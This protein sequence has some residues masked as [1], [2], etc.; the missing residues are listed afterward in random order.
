[1][2][3]NYRESYRRRLA[4]Y[5]L[6]NNRHIWVLGRLF[7]YLSI[8]STIKVA[9][10]RVFVNSSYV[11]IHCTSVIIVL[12]PGINYVTII[13]R[14][15]IGEAEMNLTINLN[16]KDVELF[17]KYASEKGITVSE[18]VRQTVLGRIED[19]YDLRLYQ[20]A[21]AELSCN[22]RLYSF[23]DIEREFMLD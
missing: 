14:I 8:I 16:D 22:P 4:K 6:K 9:T 3:N 23:G 19:D 13:V 15:T 20:E 11:K 18:L 1:M 7:F 21:M 17:E 12:I 5:V 2:Y 10:Q